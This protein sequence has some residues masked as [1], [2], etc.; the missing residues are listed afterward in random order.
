MEDAIILKFIDNKL[1]IHCD[2]FK[3]EIGTDD[4]SEAAVN[5]FTDLITY[6]GYDVVDITG[7]EEEV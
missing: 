2:E 1:I 5:V 4:I 7:L 6:L 3:A